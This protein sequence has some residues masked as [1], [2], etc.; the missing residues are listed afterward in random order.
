MAQENADP[1][2]NADFSEKPNQNMW[3]SHQCRGADIEFGHGERER[4]F[5]VEKGNVRD[6]KRGS[7]RRLDL[8]PVLV[9]A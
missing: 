9:Y 2:R 3:S 8:E 1:F 6:L 4:R 7:L 5:A